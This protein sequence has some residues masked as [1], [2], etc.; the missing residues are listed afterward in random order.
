M[1]GGRLEVTG[2]VV[3]SGA[4][5]T[6]KIAANASLYP[7]NT[8]G[9]L[10]IL[11]GTLKGGGTVEGSVCIYDGFL[12]P[13]GTAGIPGGG[14]ATLTITCILHMYGGTLVTDI[15]ARDKYDRVVVGGEAKLGGGVMGLFGGGVLNQDFRP[16]D[17]IT[18][19][20]HDSRDGDFGMV[21]SPQGWTADKSN[22][23]Y[24]FRQGAR[25]AAWPGATTT[26]TA[27]STC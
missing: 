23:Q 22:K 2:P 26:A 11:N 5:A 17:W 27:D 21:T 14:Q 1:A 10:D 9:V 8:A 15:Y 18:F 13:S 25:S 7:H 19:L 20:T 4:D 3:Q 12:D 24:W 6:F 16:G